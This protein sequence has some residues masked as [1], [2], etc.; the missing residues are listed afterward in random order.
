MLYREPRMLEPKELRCVECGQDLNNKN[1]DE[2][3]PISAGGIHVAQARN[4]PLSK[5]LICGFV[6]RE[7]SGRP[8]FYL[9]PP[10][11]EEEE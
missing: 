5:G 6:F 7:D 2:I 9:K 8:P 10:Y 1:T 3:C 11:E 4:I